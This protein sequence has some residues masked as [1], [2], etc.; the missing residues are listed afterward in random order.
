MG[1]RAKRRVVVLD[2]AELKALLIHS[3]ANQ[4]CIVKWQYMLHFSRL[5]VLQIVSVMSG[6][7]EMV[8]TQGG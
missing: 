7:C 3:H 1:V 8:H 2:F 5:E 4:G 6:H